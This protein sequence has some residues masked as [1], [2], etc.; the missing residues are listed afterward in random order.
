MFFTISFFGI[1][2]LSGYGNMLLDGFALHL[3]KNY[4]IFVPFKKIF[5]IR[6]S[7]KPLKDYHFIKLNYEFDL[8]SEDN[9]L[10]PISIAYSLNYVNNIVK[11]YLINIKPYVEF[12]GKFNVI[13]DK[14]VLNISVKLVVLL[15][16]L[17]IILSA[18]K[19]LVGKAL[20]EFRN[21]KRQNKQR[22]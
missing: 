8:G 6:N 4:A 14:N 12:N 15:N 20:N 11:Q 5:G 17:M 16:I 10:Y 13:S 2:I 3:T 21:K 9:Q 19:I 18:I 1:N 7:I 22:C